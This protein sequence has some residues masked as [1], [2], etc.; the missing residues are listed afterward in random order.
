MIVGVVVVGVAI[1]VDNAEVVTAAL[2][3]RAQ[4]QHKTA[5]N[6]YIIKR[7]RLKG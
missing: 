5:H 2:V 6:L 3:G 7:E 1:T 4:Q